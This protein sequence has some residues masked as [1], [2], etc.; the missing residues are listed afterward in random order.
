ADEEH[1]AG[2]GVLQHDRQ[3]V[4]VALR[5]ARELLEVELG[6]GSFLEGVRLGCHPAIRPGTRLARK[7][8]VQ[9]PIPFAGRAAETDVD[10]RARRNFWIACCSEDARAR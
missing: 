4:L 8:S 9:L 6:G 5:D 2:G 3:G 1:G 10:Q 7:R